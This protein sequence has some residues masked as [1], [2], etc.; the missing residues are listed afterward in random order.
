MENPSQSD[1]FFAEPVDPRVEAR[2]QISEAL[3]RLLIWM[4]DASTLKARGLRAT[5]ALYCIRPDLI[6]GATLE[7]IGTRAGITRQ[8]VHK[9]ADNFRVSLGLKS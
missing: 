3:S 6:G 9:L 5:V 2:A 7:K 8:A 4:A 1:P